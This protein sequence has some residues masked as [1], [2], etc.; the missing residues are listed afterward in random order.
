MQKLDIRFADRGDP[1]TLVFDVPREISASGQPM[2]S[3]ALPLMSRQG[4]IL[5]ALP[6]HALLE[7]ALTVRCRFARGRGSVGPFS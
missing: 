3:F 2:R 1:S 7:T 4:G 6:S 5:L